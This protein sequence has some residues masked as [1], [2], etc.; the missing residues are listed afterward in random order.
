[1]GKYKVKRRIKT[2]LKSN[3]K[4]KSNNKYSPQ[5]QQKTCLARK[6][7]NFF[8]VFVYTAEHA[9]TVGRLRKKANSLP[10]IRQPAR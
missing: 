6:D 4:T 10:R 5:T 1:M 3:I 2:K 8:F 9:L 7:P